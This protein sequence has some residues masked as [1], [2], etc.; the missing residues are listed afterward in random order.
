DPLGGPRSSRLLRWV[1]GLYGPSIRLA[2]WTWG[3]IYYA[4]DSRAAMA[5]LRRSV[6]ALADRP[7][8]EAVAE[9]RPAAIVSFHPLVGKAAVRAAAQAEGVPVINVV[10][11]L[12]APHTAWRY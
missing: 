2:P 1:T 7:V 3:A 6:L 12:I 10:T 4:S 5:F 8:A 11:D 9:H